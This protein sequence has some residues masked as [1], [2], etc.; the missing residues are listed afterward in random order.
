MHRRTRTH[1]RVVVVELGAEVQTFLQ[2]RLSGG[3]LATDRKIAAPGSTAARHVD[4]HLFGLVA[5]EE[6]ARTREQAVGQ[7]GSDVVTDQ[8]EEAELAAG[9]IEIARDRCPRLTP[10]LRDG[11]IDHRQRRAHWLE[12]SAAFK[13]SSA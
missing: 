9:E 4:A 6:L 13:L 2:I 5:G 10:A 12:N 3:E 8:V 11:Q 1:S 7:L